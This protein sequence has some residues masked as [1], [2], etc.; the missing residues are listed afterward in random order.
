MRV[1]DNDAVDGSL[2]RGQDPGQEN[3]LARVG[4][5]F[6]NLLSLLIT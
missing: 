3:Q 2:E 5:I 4:S 6:S 1:P